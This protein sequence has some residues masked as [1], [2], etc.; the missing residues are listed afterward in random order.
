MINPGYQVVTLDEDNQPLVQARI[1]ARAL[2][3]DVSWHPIDIDQDTQPRTAAVAVAAEVLQRSDSLLAIHLRRTTFLDVGRPKSY[4]A[5][6]LDPQEEARPG[7][8]PEGLVQQA[9]HLGPGGI[10]QR[11]LDDAHTI[12]R[13]AVQPRHR[14]V[15][16]DVRNRDDEDAGPHRKRRARHRR[17]VE[18]GLE[19]WEWLAPRDNTPLVAGRTP[20]PIEEEPRGMRVGL[21]D[22]VLSQSNKG[23]KERTES[24]AQNRHTEKMPVMAIRTRTGRPR[25]RPGRNAE[26]NAI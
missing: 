20:T 24:H 3:A 26:P 7:V 12:E 21:R 22:G 15:N 4:G 14:A 17:G 10:R 11:R 19:R 6:R 23:E 2:D 18:D 16:R 9:V 25:R 8:R 1:P 5:V 13:H